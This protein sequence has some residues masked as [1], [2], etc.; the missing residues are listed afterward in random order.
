[1]SRL[2]ISI[3]L[4]LLF[5]STKAQ[6]GLAE[7]FS[8]HKC[9]YKIY[10][11][12]ETKEI[13][14]G[15]TL[16]CA[17]DSLGEERPY[18]LCSYSYRVKDSNFL[19]AAAMTFKIDPAPSR[20]ELDTAD[21]S[22]FF[23]QPS[24]GKFI[25]SRKVIVDGLNSVEAQTFT[26]IELPLGKTYQKM[27]SYLLIYK[28]IGIVVTFKVMSY[29]DEP[30]CQSLFS[31]YLALFRS[32]AANIVLY[33][34]WEL[35]ESKSLPTRTNFE[36]DDCDT[37][38]LKIKFKSSFKSE[39]EHR[40]AIC[41]FWTHRIMKRVQEGE[42][43]ERWGQNMAKSLINKDTALLFQLAKSLAD[44]II[45]N[46]K[47]IFQSEIPLPIYHLH[48]LS[49]L[50]Y[51]MMLQEVEKFTAKL[52]ND[53]YMK[54]DDFV[55]NARAMADVVSPLHRDIAKELK[56]LSAKYELNKIDLSRELKHSK[57]R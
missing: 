33:N 10:G 50:Y 46:K 36:K 23:K 22:F 31:E 11:K 13:K 57:S 47:Q 41:I 12:D 39:H 17:W 29:V 14:L 45:E 24:W 55:K 5:L 35:V 20:N 19:S 43:G 1:M 34:H 32:L 8:R 44:S 15:L 42:M 7:E 38:H 51:C 16:P 26:I 54:P 40:V 49:I 52:H 3:F 53:P 2:L 18:L 4:C 56:N 27:L 37:A 21:L 28:N 6:S 9:N 48:S 30:T 25:S